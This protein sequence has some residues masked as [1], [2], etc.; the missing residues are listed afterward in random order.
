MVLPVQKHLLAAL[1]MLLWD[2][3]VA[4]SAVQSSDPHNGKRNIEPFNFRVDDPCCFSDLENSWLGER[5]SIYALLA[6]VIEGFS[7]KSNIFFLRGTILRVE[8][9][10]LFFLVVSSRYSGV[11]A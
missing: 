5:R 6:L 11:V 8:G 10:Q 3:L 1:H 2:S 7:F 9:G 4:A